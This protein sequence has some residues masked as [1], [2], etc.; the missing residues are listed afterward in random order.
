[1]V[2]LGK[3]G[4]GKSASGN[5]ILGSKEF[6]SHTASCSVTREC[7]KGSV[8]VRGRRLY[9]VDTPGFFDTQLP[10]DEF[11]REIARCVSLCAPGPHAFLLVMPVGRYTE[12]EG[13]TVQQIQERFSEEAWRHTLVLFTHGDELGG[14]P[15]E[16][17]VR[18][19]PRLQELVEKCGGRCHAFDNGN[20]GNRNQ[21]RGLLGKIDAM[22]EGA[23][24]GGGGGR[25]GG[26]YTNEMYREAEAAIARETERRVRERQAEIRR[27]EEEIQQREAGMRQRERAVREQRERME[28]ERE[29][30]RREVAEERKRL[31]RSREELEQVKQRYCICS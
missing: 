13:E 15:L 11:D 1:M 19:N 10:K 2:L 22:L 3:T 9:V 18:Q 29:R 4:V 28:A 6:D 31:E 24:G 25:G 26:C 14:E 17:F 12:H 8:K 27:E 20:T 5:T 7:R 30:E 16:E 21:V 23:G